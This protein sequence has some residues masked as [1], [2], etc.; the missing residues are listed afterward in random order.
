MVSVAWFIAGAMVVL[1][2]GPLLFLFFFWWT[3]F[4]FTARIAKQ[5]GDNVDDVIWIEDRFKVVKKD[6][7]HIIKF[8]WQRETSTSIPYKFWSKHSKK[9]P[10]WTDD[11]WK[12]LDMSKHLR[13]GL[14]LYMT[15]EG[16]YH[17]LV[18]NKSGQFQILPQDNRAHIV[19]EFEHVNDLTLTP[20]KAYIAAGILGIAVI[21]LGI[22]FV[23]YLIYLQEA[24]MA[25]LGAAQSAGNNFLN[26]AQGAVGG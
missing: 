19:S 5:A 13:R 14:H 4:K 20:K 25:A 6:G 8:R 2:G 26:A 3:S 18:I 10:T 12:T 16:E 21:V 17:P 23:F 24:Q 7:Y 1:I 22:A 15:T 9:K 11:Q